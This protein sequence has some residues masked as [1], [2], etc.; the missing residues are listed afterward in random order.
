MGGE[1]EGRGA[2]T[3]IQAADYGKHASSGIEVV[4]KYPRCNKIE[5]SE[6][7]AVPGRYGELRI[8][9]LDW[10]PSGAKMQQKRTWGHRCVEVGPRSGHGGRKGRQSA[11]K[12][13]KKVPMARPGAPRGMPFGSPWAPKAHLRKTSV[14]TM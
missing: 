10:V 12:G 1:F 8:Y 2:G 5:R 3:L 6:I 13:V 7:T 4:I 14:F 11:P 9:G